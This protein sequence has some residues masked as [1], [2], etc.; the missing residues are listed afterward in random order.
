[1]EFA[2]AV[3]A[4]RRPGTT[5]SPAFRIALVPRDGADLAAYRAILKTM[6][7]ELFHV[8]VAFAPQPRRPV[9]PSPAWGLVAVP[10]ESQLRFDAEGW[11]QLRIRL[12]LPPAVPARARC[13]LDVAVSLL[14]LDIPLQARVAQSCDRQVLAVEWRLPEPCHPLLRPDRTNGAVTSAPTYEFLTFDLPARPQ[15]I[16]SSGFVAEAGAAPASATTS[17]SGAAAP[18]LPAKEPSSTITCTRVE[19]RRPMKGKPDQYV[20]TLRIVA[21]WLGAAGFE[22]GQRMRVQVEPGRLVLTPAAPAD[23]AGEDA[24]PGTP[25]CTKGTG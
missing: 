6:L 13:K 21:K 1:M 17:P 10:A 24:Q 8:A 23:T 2:D 4:I 12:Q 20:P 22:I 25:T 9:R 3:H 18:R 5:F 7:E 15:V 11:A 19:P 14:P 16:A